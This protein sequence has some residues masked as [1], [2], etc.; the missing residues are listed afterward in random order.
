MLF[1]WISIHTHDSLLF[2]RDSLMSE[3]NS[4]LTYILFTVDIFDFIWYVCFTYKLDNVEI[5]WCYER[6]NVTFRKS[7]YL[8]HSS[9]LA[10]RVKFNYRVK[11]LSRV[12]IGFTSLI[13]S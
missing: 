5:Y 9:M 12:T 10:L 1:F 7:T 8:C 3:K 11:T 13:G 6:P 2:K 4:G